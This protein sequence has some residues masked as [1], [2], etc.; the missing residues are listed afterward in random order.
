M[1]TIAEQ[2]ASKIEDQ[3]LLADGIINRLRVAMPGIVHSY[4]A[5]KQTCTVQPAIR[6]TLRDDQG[7][8]SQVA[9]PL[10][11]DVPVVFPRAGSWAITL[12]V[13]KGDECLVIFADACIDAW[14]QS[15]GVQNPAELRRHDLSDAIAILGPTSQPKKLANV[16]GDGIELRN[17]AGNVKIKLGAGGIDLQ[18]PV[19]RINGIDFNAHT[20]TNSAGQTGGPQ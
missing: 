5:E 10:L 4:N 9:L 11:L 13:Q 6:E 2:A 17:L 14:W 18:A 8:V 12:P 19:V 20:H 15:G 16:A 1:R 3:A 7:M